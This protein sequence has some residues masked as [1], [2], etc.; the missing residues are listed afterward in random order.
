V[1]GPLVGGPAV[2]DDEEV[3]ARRG[4]QGP[5]E[6]GGGVDVPVRG[7]ATLLGDAGDHG[8]HALEAEAHAAGDDGGHGRVVV[9]GLL[10]DPGEGVDVW[11]ERGGGLHQGVKRL[12][13]GGRRPDRGEQRA[14]VV[15]CTKSEWPDVLDA[16][17]D[18][19]TTTRPNIDLVRLPMT[20]L[21]PVTDGLD[22]TLTH[23]E[24]FLA[25]T[26]NP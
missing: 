14:Q 17:L 4:G 5:H 3:V 19:L 15:R 2:F 25:P 12:F 23:I 10:G 1:S 9:A 13:A 6:R 20:H 7:E 16:E 11:F 21:G 8:A 26:R 22:Q 18:H 24:R